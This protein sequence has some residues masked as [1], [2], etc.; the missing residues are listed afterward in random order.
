MQIKLT[1]DVSL[2]KLNA[3]YQYEPILGKNADLTIHDVVDEWY[4]AQ[5]G[6]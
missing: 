5:Q 6:N 1:Y 3:D 4:Q 2:H